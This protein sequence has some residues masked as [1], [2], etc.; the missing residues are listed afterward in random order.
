MCLNQKCRSISELGFLGCEGGCSKHGVCNSKGNCHCEE[1]W[2]PPSCNGAGNG[3]S[4][5]S[6]PIK[7][8]GEWK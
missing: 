6:G 2:G 5:D 8:E 1:G 4:V 3:G 7:I